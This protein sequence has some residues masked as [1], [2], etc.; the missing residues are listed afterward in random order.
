MKV[1]KRI[2]LALIALIIIATVAFFIYVNDFYEASE[3]VDSMMNQ[4]QDRIHVEDHLTIIDAKESSDIGIVFYPG[5]KV[6]AIAYLPLL[7][8]LANENIHCVLVEMPFNL[9]VFNIDGGIEAIESL[10]EVND[11]YLM[12]HS[13][14]GAMASQFTEENYDLFEGL[15][16]LGA[17]PVNDAPIETMT[18]YGTYDIMLDLDKVSESDIIYEI[19]GGNHAYFG[20]YGEQDG[21][22][23]A[24]ISRAAQQAFA[25]KK[26]IEFIE[27]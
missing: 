21:D 19:E 12:G 26:I 20:D 6:E 1:M 7:M 24:V 2:G 14:G 25:V 15:I 23:K 11:W 16:L 17:Y 9:A 8:Q 18:L 27:Q 3:N 13:L 10:P 22:G 4:Y 5:G